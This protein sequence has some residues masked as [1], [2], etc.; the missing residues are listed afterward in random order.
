MWNLMLLQPRCETSVKSS[1][2]T[3]RTLVE[4]DSRG[5]LL[6]KSSEFLW[7]TNWADSPSAMGF[8]LSSVPH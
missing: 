3:E 8:L 1:P 2:V 5:G 4:D 7:S 6:K